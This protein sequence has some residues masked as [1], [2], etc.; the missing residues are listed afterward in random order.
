MK[1]SRG[2][3]F[4]LG[5]ALISTLGFKLLLKPATS[6]QNPAT[7]AQSRLADFLTR[8]HFR[9]SVVENAAEGQASIVASTGVCRILAV[10]SPAMGWDRDL[11]RR[12]ASAG[13][14]VFVLYRGK[15]YDE[16]PTLRTVS[17]F[18]WGRILRELGISSADRAIYA[19]ISPRSCNASLLPWDELAA[20]D[21]A[22]PLVE[23]T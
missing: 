21:R 23:L 6:S 4:L 15:I 10:R 7:A 16:Q 5:L 2:F 12:Q 3:K 8:Q 18:L 20:V 19:I 9:V 22:P 14:E 1:Y 11:V 13:D 17:D